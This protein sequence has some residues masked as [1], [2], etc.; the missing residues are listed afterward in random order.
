MLVIAAP[1]LVV[2]GTSVLGPGDCR[3]FASAVVTG[4]SWHRLSR[5]CPAQRTGGNRS[6]H[7]QS[8][9]RSSIRNSPDKP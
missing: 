5:L 2:L 9:V 1:S 4:I 8:R 6:E 7:H 3:L